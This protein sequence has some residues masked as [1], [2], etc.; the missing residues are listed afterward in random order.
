[1]SR[2]HNKKSKAIVN[3]MKNPDKILITIL[4]GNL[5]V[6]FT[7]TILTTNILLS[8]FPS[9]GQFISILIVTPLMVLFCEISPKILAI[10]RY[11]SMTRKAYP[12]LFGFH[13][14]F[15]PIRFFLMGLTSFLI[16]LF[17]LNLGGDRITEDEL[18][19]LIETGR[20]EGILEK[21]E[22]DILKNVMKFSKREAY[23]IMY[24]RNQATFIPYGISIKEA[25]GIFLENNV[26]RA[27]V[28]KNDLDHVVGVIDSRELLPV[29]LGYKKGTNINKYIKDIKHYP[30]SRELND[31]LNDFLSEGIQIAI[32]LDEYGGTAGVVTL[33]LLLSELMG[34]KFTN[35]NAEKKDQIKMVDENTS[36]IYGDMQIDDYNINFN[37]SIK[38]QNSDTVGGF[39]IESYGNFPKRGIEV[40]TGRNTL[41][42]KYLKKNKV[43]SV[44]V[45]KENLNAK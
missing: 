10:S 44:E 15:L 39:I 22:E 16:R 43:V 36:A 42:V 30:A 24:P 19:L 18:D 4:I 41:R 27:P 13:Y 1:M 7:I 9:Y 21:E 12:F 35:V 2:S 8:I 33:N 37:D 26:I 29:H 25:M 11:E 23:N 45:I 38:S 31:L 40:D 6:N 17:K 32:A 34:K 14:L 28:F 5:F 3:W 20:E